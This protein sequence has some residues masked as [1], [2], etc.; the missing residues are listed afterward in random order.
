MIMGVLEKIFSSKSIEE[1]KDENDRL[2]A[3][4]KDME[5]RDETLK[6]NERLKDEIKK[7]KISIFKSSFLGKSS[8]ILISVA[9]E[10]GKKRSK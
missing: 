1:L 9:K 8:K 4:K 5:I 7:H 10:L 2:E 3:L 6:N